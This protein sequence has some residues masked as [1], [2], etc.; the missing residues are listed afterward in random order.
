MAE[1]TDL[2]TGWRGGDE[3]AFQQLVPLIYDELKRVARRS[4]AGERRAVTLNCT[5][6]VHETY[7]RLAGQRE[8]NW[9][10][11]AHF[12]GAAASLMRRILIENARKRLTGKRGAGAEQVDLN[13]FL[14]VSMAPDL[15]AIDLDRALEAL[16]KTDAESARVVEL[17]C[18]GGLSIEETAEVLN[19][20]P[21]SVTRMWSYARAWLY[22]YLNRPGLAA[23]AEEEQADGTK[24]EK[25]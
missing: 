17:R 8:P 22:R 11:R 24:R 4:L 16:E 18:F 19:T 20:S 6:L 25:A 15:N 12:F 2:I 3:S 21:S 10:G 1:I 13:A 5:A 23:A 9:S 14:A 7:L